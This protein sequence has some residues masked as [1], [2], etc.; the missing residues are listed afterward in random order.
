MDEVLEVDKRY[1]FDVLRLNSPANR[2]AMSIALLE[3]TLDA[4]ERSRADDGSRGLIFDHHGPVFCSGIDLRERRRLA[5]GDDR[6]TQLLADLLQLLWAYPKPV[7]C[8]VGGAVRGGGMGLLAC[9]DAVIASSSASFAYAEVKVG[10]AP[11]LVGALA[12][13][14]APSGHLLPWLLTGET[15]SAK[16]AQQLGL[17]SHVTDDSTALLDTFAETMLLAAPGAAAT[18]KRIAREIVAPS[19]QQTIEDMRMRSG[20]LFDTDEAREGMAAFA[21]RRRPS[22]AVD[23]EPC[24]PNR[25]RKE[26][27]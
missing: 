11:A 2:N 10:V 25:S 16:Q 13:M 24:P 21:Q 14:K 20:P 26:A 8:R 4:V 5:P 15:F 18:T 12:L 17:V 19:A 9:A 1:R 6:Q 22:W 7:L 3:A 27:P 23:T